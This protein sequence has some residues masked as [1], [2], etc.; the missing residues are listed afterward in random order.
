[1]YYAKTSG[2]AGFQIFEQEMKES[3]SQRLLLEQ[4]LRR[5]LELNQFEIHYQ[6][7]LDTETEQLIGVEALIRWNH[8]QLGQVSPAAFIP[9]A[10]HS[11]LILEMDRRTLRRAC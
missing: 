11:R 1:M 7:Q 10:E 5:A 3:T 8:P 9:V 4:E 6:P 2:K